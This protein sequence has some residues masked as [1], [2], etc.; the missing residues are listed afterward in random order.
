MSRYPLCSAHRQRGDVIKNLSFEW[1]LRETSSELEDI[2]FL[3][4]TLLPCCQESSL[5]PRNPVF[6]RSHCEMYLYYLQG[7][8]GGWPEAHFN[9]SHSFVEQLRTV[10]QRGEGDWKQRQAGPALEKFARKV[11]VSPQFAE[12]GAKCWVKAHWRLITIWE[13]FSLYEPSICY[14]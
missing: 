2:L 14:I 10:R 4:Q 1:F 12:L 7:P 8:W 6:P 11:P 9:N 3:S 13:V 5:E